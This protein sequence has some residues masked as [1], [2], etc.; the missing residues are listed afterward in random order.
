MFDD[1]EIR[2]M[3]RDILYK[4][5]CFVKED[6]FSNINKLAEIIGYSG[7]GKQCK[8]RKFTVLVRKQSDPTEIFYID[9]YALRPRL[10]GDC[11]SLVLREITR[12][13]AEML[14]EEGYTIAADVTRDNVV[15]HESVLDFG[16]FSDGVDSRDTIWKGEF[17]PEDDIAIYVN[18][19]YSVRRGPRKEFFAHSFGKLKKNEP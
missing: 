10:D 1:D 14:A 18:R 2:G 4:N 12:T 13:L 15:L 7:K 19:D 8:F 17:V 6:H 16:W 9:A 3:I 11:E 5:T